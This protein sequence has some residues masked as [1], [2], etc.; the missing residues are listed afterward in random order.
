MKFFRGL[1]LILVTVLIISCPQAT[2]DPSNPGTDSSSGTDLQ[3]KTEVLTESEKDAIPFGDL[4]LIPIYKKTTTHKPILLSSQGGA[5]GSASQEVEEYKGELI[6]YAVKAKNKNID[7]DI[8]IPTEFNDIPIIKIADDGFKDCEKVTTIEIPETVEEVGA[9]A[10]S[11]CENLDEIKVDEKNTHIKLNKDFLF[12]AD[13]KTLQLYMG[14]DTEVTIPD[15]VERIHHGAFSGNNTLIKVTIPNSVK[16][17]EGW[18]FDWCQNLENIVL[19]NNLEFIG[20]GAFFFCQSLTTIEI[21]ASVQTIED[22]PFPD[23]KNLYEITV[24]SENKNYIAT[25]GVL[26]TADGKTLKQYPAGKKDTSFSVPENVTSI[27]SNTF[28]GCNKLKNIEF[29]EGL[30]AIGHYSFNNCYALESIKIPKTVKTIGNSPFIG[31]VSLQVL[32]TPLAKKPNTWHEN[33]NISHYQDMSKRF[34]THFNCNGTCKKALIEALK[35]TLSE[36]ETYYVVEPTNNYI[37]GDITIPGTHQEK[38]VKIGPFN[39]CQNIT[40]ITFREGIK[41]IPGLSFGQCPNLKKI[42]IP[43]S[44]ETIDGLALSEM[45]SLETIDLSGNE[46]FEIVDNVLYTKGKKCLLRYLASNKKEH[47]VIPNET[48][49]IGG[50]AFSNNDFLKTITFGAKLYQPSRLFV[51]NCKNLESFDV[52]EGNTTFSEKDGVLFRGDALFQYPIGKKADVY[53][54]PEGITRIEESAFYQVRKTDKIIIPEGVTSIDFQAFAYS[55]IKNIY[56]PSSVETIGSYAFSN[57]QNL[58]LCTIKTE[59][60]ANNWNNTDALVNPDH[61]WNQSDWDGIETIP[62]YYECNGSC[63][64]NPHEEISLSYTLNENNTYTVK[65]QNKK[66]IGDENG[67]IEIPAT[68]KGI[69]VTHIDNNAFSNCYNIKSISIGDNITTIGKAAFA[70]AVLLESIIFSSEQ[71][72]ETIGESCFYQ[73]HSLNSIA[74]PEGV[75]TIDRAA[76]MDCISI[77]SIKLP[78]TLVNFGEDQFYRDDNVFICINIESAPT[79]WND[80]WNN[81]NRPVNWG[82]NGNCTTPH[83]PGDLFFQL[84]NDGTYEVRATHKDISGEIKIPSH[85][86]DKTVTRIA[87]EAFSGCSKITSITL[88]ET[89]TQADGWAFFFC[90]KLEN[91][92][93]DT[94]NSNLKSIDGVLYS[95]DGSALIAYPF[96]RKD[97]TFTVPRGTRGIWGGAFT[98]SQ[99]IEKIILPSSLQWI[100]GWAFQWC[101]QLREIDTSNCTYFTTENEVIYSHDKKSLVYYPPYKT[102]KT[103]DVPETV[104][105]I[106]QCAFMNNKYIKN[107]TLPHGL[108]TINWEAFRDTNIEHIIIPTTVT[109]ISGRIF[110]GNKNIS[111]CTQISEENKPATWEE[112]WDSTGWNEY[113]KAYVNWACDGTCGFEHDPAPAQLKPNDTFSF[114]R[115]ATGLT[116]SAKD[117]NISGHI[118]IPSTWEDEE[119]TKYNVTEIAERGFSECNEL[120]SV[121]VSDGVT[122]LGQQSFWNSRNLKS[123]KLPSSITKIGCGSF[124]DTNGLVVCFNKENYNGDGNWQG[125]ARF[126]WGCNGSCNGHEISDFIFD[127]YTENGLDGYSVSAYDRNIIGENGIITIPSTHNEKP[128]VAIISNREWFNNCDKITQIKIPNS[129]QYIWEGAFAR[130]NSLEK[131]IV[132][133]DNPYFLVEDDVLYTKDK[134]SIIFYPINKTSPSFTVPEGVTTLG[135]GLFS[136]NKSL[137]TVHLPSTLTEIS[138]WTFASTNIEHILIPESVTRIYSWAFAENENITIC[139]QVS[140]ANKPSG[141]VNS[142][143]WGYWNANSWVNNDQ[144]TFHEDNIH[145]SCD[146]KTCGFNHEAPP[147]QLEANDKLVFT[148]N[149]NGTLT[150]SAKNTDISGTVVI[151]STW[152]DEDD[153]VFNVTEIAERGFTGCHNITGVKIP[154]TIEMIGRNAFVNCPNVILCIDRQG[155]PT[156]ENGYLWNGCWDGGNRIAWNCDG[157][158]SEGDHIFSDFIFQINDNGTYAVYPGGDYLSG[159]ISIPS[160]HEGKSVTE[161]RHF[162]NCSNL[163]SIKI[164]ASIE[165]IDDANIGWCYNLETIDVSE[166]T[167]FIKENDVIYN[168][169]K[170]TIVFYPLDKKDTNF[171]IPSSVTKIIPGCFLNR[172]YLQN[173]TLP[174][175]LQFIGNRALGSTNLTNLKIPVNVEIIEYNAFG[176]SDDIKLCT[177]LSSK[178][179]RWNN[180]WNRNWDDYGN[181]TTIPITWGCD[182]TS[183]GFTH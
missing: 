31:C 46:N 79:T 45:H 139:T 101:N 108:I 138:N 157:S 148:K 171:E 85:Y 52:A 167:H 159:D 48:E 32:C 132:E 113:D 163:T 91:I 165:Y 168:A 18:A 2:M 118:E 13:G 11:S 99:N 36:D 135:N 51:T 153:N 88:P 107:I 96:G 54:I 112:N 147:A 145:W 12:S 134:K 53:E 174:E 3:P 78:S 87:N 20:Q 7:G 155:V 120:L 103:F 34:V 77:E 151:P 22:A 98:Q 117:K 94:E 81:Y 180:E 176:G 40:S 92:Y 152:N 56:I 144:Y 75:K 136:E 29:K 125:N 161:M 177:S 66:I 14:N 100:N 71:K 116:V 160:E 149:A 95:K 83:T 6:G 1:L 68:H 173:V 33:W 166:N 89:I 9:G 28:A 170:T 178:P 146:G 131:I 27:G 38:P 111:V 143:D 61:V 16:V 169:N 39:W 181:E 5:S 182:G 62:T 130:C 47:F 121:K 59:D 133:K 119:N 43:K 17:I 142:E 84:L 156:D 73:C 58:T 64:D 127:K 76:F 41:E 150:V 90:N 19:P 109:N 123:V 35:Y 126:V 124:C 122:T 158:C 183:C 129:I 141:W 50:Q 70:N 25:D 57:T 128:V 140:K 154:S 4:L 82:C 106:E 97:K 26:Y 137:K 80:W 104:K 179:D 44:L 55:S 115:N 10:F 110:N 72:L 23:C 24:A 74:I 49:T 162:G 67:H 42:T 21:P 63:S 172:K 114:V 105:T 65:A 69:D 8:I 175:N 93:V 102:D 164:P 86:K 30:T 15:G 60:K 37:V